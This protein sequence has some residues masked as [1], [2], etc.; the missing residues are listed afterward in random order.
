MSARRFAG[1]LQ[2]VRRSGPEGIPLTLVRESDRLPLS[3]DAAGGDPPPPPGT[4]QRVVHES[5]RPDSPDNGLFSAAGGEP[6][7]DW[8]RAAGQG[9]GYGVDLL[10]VRDVFHAPQLGAVIDPE[11]GVFAASAAEALFFTP[12]LGR[13]PAV[14]VR[15]GQARFFPTGG[16][17]RLAAASVFL[18]WGARFNYGHFLLD[19]LPGLVLLADRGLLDRFPALAPALDPWQRELLELTL[20]TGESVEETLA[21]LVRVDD[22]LFTSCMD[23]FLHAPNAP[24][25][26]VRSR[27]LAGLPDAPSGGSRRLY[28]SRRSERKR[29]LVNE[30]ELEAGLVARG[31]QVVEPQRLAVREQVELFRSAEAVVA[32][33][34]AALANT[35]F[36]P[37]GAALF[38]IQPSNFMGVWVRGL[39]QYVG[40]RWHGYFCPSPLAA[41]HERKPPGGVPDFTWQVPAADFLAYVDAHL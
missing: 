5:V 27:I 22:L 1:W 36:L 33:T 12:D 30:A 19:A 4:R 2:G 37:P 15:A 29:R 28:L 7:P 31:F 34:G 17:L 32:P 21:P 40:A 39:A 16:E 25:D 13:L 38:E 41:K 20:K 14:R 23:H 3:A 11:G 10:R 26:S 8:A 35:L 9:Y 6:L 24:L 18:P